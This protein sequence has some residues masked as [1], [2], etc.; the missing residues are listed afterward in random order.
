MFKGRVSILLG[1]RRAQA[2]GRV[3][4]EA[5]LVRLDG[6]LV[7]ARAVERVPE[8]GVGLGEGRID[9]E[10]VLGV[11]DGRLVRLQLRVSGSPVGG[12]GL[13]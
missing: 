5:V 13:P 11:R 12:E 8:A 3:H 4:L 9:L 7:L 1:R 2:Y 10:R 6:G